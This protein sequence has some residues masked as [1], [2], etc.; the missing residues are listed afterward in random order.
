M[1]AQCIIWNRNLLHCSPLRSDSFAFTSL[2]GSYRILGQK[3][4]DFSRSKII[5]SGTYF[6]TIWHKITRNTIV[7]LRFQTFLFAKPWFLKEV[8][9]FKELS[10]ISKDY[11]GKIKD[12]SRRYKNIANFKDFSRTW[13]CFKDYSRPV[14]TVL[15]EC[16]HQSLIKR[17]YIN[18][19]FYRLNFQQFQA[20]LGSNK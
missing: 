3:F 13:Y 8:T 4:K 6:P 7:Q 12:F 9:L 5:F 20:I 10:Q 2:H 11:R 1:S 18:F 16:R 19:L 17:M 14:Q 15:Y